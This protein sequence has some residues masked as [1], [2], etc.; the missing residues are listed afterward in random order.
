[1]TRKLL[2][3]SSAAIA[4]SLLFGFMGAI[5]T[6]SGIDGW[7]PE[8]NK[9]W[10]TPPNR[11]IGPVWI[12][13]YLLMGIAAGIV[14]NRGFYH[15]WVKTALYHFGFQLLLN[16]SWSLLFF[17]IQQPFF[18]LLNI[19]ALFLLILLTIKWFKVVS[20][21]AAYLLIPYA[22]WVLFAMLLNFEIWRLNTN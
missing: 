10:F 6:Q 1:L 8:L 17:G 4:I 15:K 5:A 13:M 2:I 11:I 12:V 22:V 9:P 19:I 16:G 21:R 18:A 20:T 3:Q 7:Y 14:W